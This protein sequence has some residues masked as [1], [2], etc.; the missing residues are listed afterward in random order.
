MRRLEHRGAR[1]TTGELKR[2]RDGSRAPRKAALAGAGVQR[3]DTSDWARAAQ[4]AG[5]VAKPRTRLRTPLAGLQLRREEAREAGMSADAD[6]EVAA[7]SLREDLATGPPPFDELL[8]LKPRARARRDRRGDEPRR[9]RPYWRASAGARRVEG[10]RPATSTSACPNAG[11]A[12]WR[13]SSWNAH[14]DEL[15]RER[16]RLAPPVRTVTSASRRAAIGSSTIARDAEDEW[17]TYSSASD[18]G[19]RGQGTR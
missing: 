4:P 13:R 1:S 7:G 15:H 11:P 17:P 16:G 2:A 19:A 14:S 6:A 12:W 10:P 8:V 18:E 5:L 3:H 9:Q